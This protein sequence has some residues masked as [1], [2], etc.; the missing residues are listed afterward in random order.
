MKPTLILSDTTDTQNESKAEAPSRF[1]HLGGMKTELQCKM[2]S[3]SISVYP[4]TRY[5]TS[6]SFH[7][8]CIL[9]I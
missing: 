1:W 4:E 2:P 7:I 9:R 3:D 6:S 5:I 8:K